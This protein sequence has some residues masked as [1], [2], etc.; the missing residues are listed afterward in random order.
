MRCRRR[1]AHGD[2]FIPWSK[3]GASVAENFVAACAPCNLAKSAHFPSIATAVLITW[4]R[5]RYF[6]ADLPR[7]PGKRYDGL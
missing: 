2:H 7:F 3:G 5:R 4:R 1:S 6:P